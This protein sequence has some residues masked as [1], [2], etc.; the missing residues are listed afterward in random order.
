MRSKVTAIAM[1]FPAHGR[2]KQTRPVDPRDRARQ[3]G[4]APAAFAV[5]STVLGP[6]ETRAYDPAAW[7]DALVGVERGAL[8]LV[9]VS[10]A[11]G[12]F[13]RG[14]VLSLSALPLRALRNPGTEPAVLVAISR[15][16]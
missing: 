5:R 2:H 3:E 11:R 7:G 6:G 15:R 13:A 8:E 9:G 1:T 10:G 12:R 4:P 14:A 16:R